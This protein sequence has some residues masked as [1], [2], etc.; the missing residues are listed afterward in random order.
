MIHGNV[1]AVKALIEGGAH[2]DAKGEMGDTLLAHAVGNKFL[3]IVQ[4]L[5]D[6]RADV[7]ARNRK[8]RKTLLYA[9]RN[10]DMEFVQILLA[11]RCVRPRAL[12]RTP[13]VKNCKIGEGENEWRLSVFVMAT[14]RVS[15][16]LWLRFW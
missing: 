10:G 2:L 9:V 14:K 11:C 15:L 7:Q 4:I 13:Q 8:R 16:F 1:E 3:H 6:A 5:L 12:P